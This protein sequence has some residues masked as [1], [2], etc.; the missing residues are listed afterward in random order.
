[1]RSSPLDWVW[2]PIDPP[3]WIL[4]GI[5]R[6]LSSLYILTVMVPVSPFM[7]GIVISSID[8]KS[9]LMDA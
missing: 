6:Y 5:M 8:A 7:H 2:R 9:I 4:V 1:M 3:G